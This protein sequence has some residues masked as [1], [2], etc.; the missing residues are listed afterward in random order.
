MV[1]GSK[2][3]MYFWKRCVLGDGLFQLSTKDTSNSYSAAI[4][5]DLGFFMHWH[6]TCVGMCVGW[7]WFFCPLCASHSIPVV[8]KPGP[9]GSSGCG[10]PSSSAFLGGPLSEL[11]RRSR[12]QSCSCTLLPCS[13][14]LCSVASLSLLPTAAKENVLKTNGF[15][16]TTLV[17]LLGSFML[18]TEWHMRLSEKIDFRV[19]HIHEA[20]L[21][22][23]WQPHLSQDQCF[24]LLSPM[25]GFFP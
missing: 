12:S 1:R 18:D 8:I 24:K 2:V 22:L 6:V 9:H 15:Y 14:R 13:M 25:S 19:I 5:T 17:H 20:A 7:W 11:C 16:C 3:S 21:W 4:V 23:L 10:L